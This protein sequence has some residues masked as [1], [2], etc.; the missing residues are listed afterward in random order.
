MN[1]FHTAMAAHARLVSAQK[2]EFARQLQ[3][4]AWL[5]DTI[6]R[7]MEAAAAADGASV[8]EAERAALFKLEAERANGDGGVRAAGVR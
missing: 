7:G 2:A 8:G 6:L 4:L 5:S 3:Q 1:A